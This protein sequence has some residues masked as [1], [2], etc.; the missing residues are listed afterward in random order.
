MLRRIK[1]IVSTDKTVST[2]KPFQRGKQEPTDKLLQRTPGRHEKKNS[3]GTTI[4]RSKRTLK[5]Q[6]KGSTDNI[7]ERTN[8]S[9]GQKRLPD[10]SGVHE[11]KYKRN[12]ATQFQDTDRGRGIILQPSKIKTGEKMSFFVISLIN[13]NG[14]DCFSFRHFDNGKGC[15]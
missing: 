11:K 13:P 12:P 9:N 3:T 4:Q 2:D 5:K 14:L 15:R 6:K 10:I 7:V 8:Q 1:T